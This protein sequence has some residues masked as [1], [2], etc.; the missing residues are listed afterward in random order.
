[1]VNT[2]DDIRGTGYRVKLEAFEGPLD[3]LLYLIKRD[4]V[5]IYDIP[6]SNITEQYLEQVRLLESLDLEVAGEFLLMASMLMRIKAKMLLPRQIDDDEEDEGDPRNELVQRLLEYRKYKRIAEE[7]KESAAERH[8]MVGRL[9]IEVDAPE[10]PPDL[11]IPVDIVGLLQTIATLLERA[12]RMDSYEVI[13]D[14]ITLEEKIELVESRIRMEDRIEFISLFGENP[15]RLEIVVTFV[16]LLELM[17]LQKITLSQSGLFGRIWIRRREGEDGTGIE[18][19]QGTGRGAGTNGEGGN[20]DRPESRFDRE[21][22]AESQGERSGG[23]DTSDGHQ[24]G[25]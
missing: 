19:E 5:D 13:L 10:E 4:E 23:D 11:V 21:S 7:L 3:L 17:R 1:M 12:P 14:E 15:R 9:A 6:I 18:Q 22:D 8:Q 16:A 24:E 2:A 25:S 20:G